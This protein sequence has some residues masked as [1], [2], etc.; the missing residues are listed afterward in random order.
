MRATSWS[1][2]LHQ[3]PNDT[4]PFYHHSQS[5][6]NHL[7]SLKNDVAILTMSDDTNCD[8]TD[9]DVIIDCRG[10]AMIQGISSDMRHKPSKPLRSSKFLSLRVETLSKS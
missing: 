5:E 9:H 3:V 2:G 7:L 10:Q 4:I 1:S 8:V 6:I